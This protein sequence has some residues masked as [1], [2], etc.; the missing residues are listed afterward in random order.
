MKIIKRKCPKCG[1]W[2][3]FEDSFFAT[4]IEE[5]NIYTTHCGNFTTDEVEKMEKIWDEGEEK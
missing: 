5:L 2:H 1:G 4:Y 3:D